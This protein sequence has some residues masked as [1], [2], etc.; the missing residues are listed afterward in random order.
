MRGPFRDPRSTL[1]ACMTDL[2]EGEHSDHA[3][4][5]VN[6]RQ[7]PRLLALHDAYELARVPIV[8]EQLKVERRRVS[9]ACWHAT[10]G[11]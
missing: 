11:S 7:T 1:G 9:G 4:V 2:A 10:R 8:A 6:D 5:R 3:L